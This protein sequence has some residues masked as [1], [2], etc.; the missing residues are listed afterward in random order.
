MNTF[1]LPNKGDYPVFF[2]TYISKLSQENYSELIQKQLIELK[3]YFEG[4]PAGWE[5]AS[6]AEEYVAQARFSS[7]SFS[8]LI[9]DFKMQRLALL[10]FVPTLPEEVLDWV[11]SVNGNPISSRA[12]LWIIPG[13]MEH[14]LRIFKDRY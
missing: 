9:R 13:H 1:S 6:Y 8:D 2:E 7:V 3:T 10:S 14:H 5:N 4:K 12:L 11:G